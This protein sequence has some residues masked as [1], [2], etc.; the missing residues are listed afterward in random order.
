MIFAGTGAAV[1]YTNLSTGATFSSKSNGAVNQV[2]FN[3][4][5][6]VTQ[7]ATGHNLLILFPNDF[8]PGPKTTLYAGRFVL[9]VDVNNVFTVIEESGNKTDICAALS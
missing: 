7:K 3:L 9:R 6:S 5:G 4:D 2:T 1:R 8:P